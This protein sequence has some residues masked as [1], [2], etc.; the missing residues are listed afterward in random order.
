MRNKITL[1]GSFIIFGICFFT[2]SVRAMETANAPAPETKEGVTMK[3]NFYTIDRVK[4]ERGDFVGTAL[5][6]EGKLEVKITD[7]KLEK[8]LK[9]PYTT[10]TGEIKDGVARDRLI[11]YQPGTTDHLRALAVECYRFGYVAE[12]AN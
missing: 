3:V 6:K 12:I 11:T 5:L 7:P 4:A 8:I 10:M 1:V 2:F 9:E